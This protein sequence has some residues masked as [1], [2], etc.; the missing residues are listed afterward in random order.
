[1]IFITKTALTFSMT[2]EIGNTSTK[3]NALARALQGYLIPIGSLPQITITQF[4]F[5]FGASSLTLYSLFTT[6]YSLCP[7]LFIYDDV[8]L[9]TVAWGKDTAP[10]HI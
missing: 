10:I 2:V 5:I 3:R 7:L 1:M 4:C 8:A 9:C 6:L